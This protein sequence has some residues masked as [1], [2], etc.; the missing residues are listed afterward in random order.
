MVETISNLDK[1]IL[2]WLN[3]WVGEFNILDHFV[4]VLVSDYFIPVLFS[5]VLLA[6]LF[7]GR[8]PLLRRLYQKRVLAAFIAVGFGALGV[9]FL[10][11]LFSRARPFVEHNLDMLFYRSTDPS[12]PSETAA[13]AFA[14]AASVILLNRPLG[15]VMLFLAAAFGLSRVYAGAHYPSDIVVGALI[16]A[17]ASVVGL[18]WIWVLTPIFNRLHPFLQRL[19]LA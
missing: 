13:F 5:M 10:D 8:T 17:A 1:D 18:F 9:D 6:L 3:R 14:V 12:F 11:S 15:L 19:S 2:L 16:G 4:R 7:A